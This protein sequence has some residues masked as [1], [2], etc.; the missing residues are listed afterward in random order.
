MGECIIGGIGGGGGLNIKEGK[1]L[2]ES[3][4]NRNI[5]VD[6]GGHPQLVLIQFQNAGSYAGFGTGEFVFGVGDGVATATVTETG[7]YMSPPSGG[8]VSIAHIRYLAIM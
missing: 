6:L 4:S 3:S 2:P 8:W 5:S 1:V 7:F